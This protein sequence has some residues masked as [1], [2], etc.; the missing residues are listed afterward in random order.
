MKY[1]LKSQARRMYLRNNPEK[2]PW[3]SSKKFTSVPCEILKNILIDNNISY[4]PEFQPLFPER[5]F[6]I[7]IAFPDKK[8]GI[9]INGNQHYNSDGTL[10]DYYQNRRNLILSHGWSLYEYHYSLMYDEHFIKLLIEKIKSD[11]N[12]SK[13]DYSYYIKTK[14]VIHCINCKNILSQ[15]TKSGLCRSCYN[16]SDDFLA[17]RRLKRKIHISKEDLEILIAHKSY[18]SIGK[19]LGVSDNAIK[20]YAKRLGIVLPKRH[21]YPQLT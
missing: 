21:A 6:S 8:V 1:P 11:Y 4:V 14:K 19:I 13:V 9:E 20:K 17:I 7:D 5:F 2:H 15:D 16:N 12:L 18:V 10:K 3:K